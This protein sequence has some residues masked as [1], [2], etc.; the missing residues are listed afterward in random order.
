M[1]RYTTLQDILDHG[2]DYLGSNPSEGARR[3]CMRAALE[4]Y[5]DLANAFNWSYLYTQ[6]RIITS[7]IFNGDAITL[8]YTHTGGTYERMV[9]IS[10]STW[11]EWAGDGYIRVGTVAYKVD[12]RKSATVVTLDEQVNPG[13]DI[14]SGTQFDLYRDTYLLPE[15]YIAQDQALYEQ[16]FGGMCFKRPKDWLYTNRYVFASGVPQEYTITG[17]KKYPGRLVIKLFPW[18]TEAK[19]IDFIYKRR[20]SELLV[21]QESTGKVSMA[22]DDTTLT[23]AGTAFTSRMVGSVVRLSATTKAPTSLIMSSTPAVFESFV[24]AYVSPTSLVLADAADQAYDAVGFTLS[25]MIDIEPGAMLNAYLR[26]V[27]KHL[28]MNRTLKDKPSAANQYAVALSEAKSADS[29]SF[30]GR[31]VGQGRPL[32]RNLR[33]YPQDLSQTY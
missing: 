4:S 1:S 15:D 25:D 18:P 27:E 7:A 12:E 17:D 5:R 9:T 24:K 33:D 28:G 32:R 23:G 13:V 19:S 2:Q 14:A 11:P 21:S 31:A 30:S 26:C 22:M 10:G 8:S 16:N 20:P 29:R 3:D 6:G